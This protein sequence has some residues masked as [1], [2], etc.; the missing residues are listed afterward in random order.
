MSQGAGDSSLTATVTNAFTDDGDVQSTDGPLSGSGDTTVFHYDAMR[1]RTGI[2]GPDPDSGGSLHNRALRYTYDGDGQVTKVERGTAPS[3][4]DSD[5]TSH[6][7]TLEELDTTYNSLAQRVQDAFAAGGTTY[8]VTQYSYDSA[9]RPDCTA[10][11]LNPSIFGSLPSSA[12]TLGTE[13][14]NGPD[15]ISRNVYDQVNRVIQVQGAYGTA[16]QQTTA[17]QTWTGNSQLATLADANGNLTTYVHDGFDRLSKIEFP[18]ATTAG[19]SN[20]SDYEGYGYDANSNVTSDRRRDG[21][22]FALTYDN[23]NRLITAD[24]PTGT[25]DVDYSY[26]LFGRRT[27]AQTSTQTLTWAYDQL[28]RN[29][30]AGAPLGTVSYQYDLAGQR[31]RITWPDSLYAQYDYDLTGAV[32]AIRENGAT[33]GAGVL[34]TYAYDDYARRTSITRGNGVTTTY[35]YDGSTRLSSLAHDLASTGSDQTISYTYNAG[36]QALTRTGT[37]ASY[38]YTPPTG[39]AYTPPNGLNQ[40]VS[41]NAATLSYDTR[42]NLTSDGTVSYSYDAYNRLTAAGSA[43]LSYDPASRLYQTAGAATT[44]FLSDGGEVIA[45]Y[46]TSGTLLRRFVHGPGIDEPIVWY[47]GSGTSDRR[48]LV[49]NEQNTVIAVT[50]AS[51]AA[52]TINTYDEYG[53]PG[54]SNAGRFQF[55]GQM[56]LPEASQYDFKARM[57][58]AAL[59]RFMQTDP[60][61]Q[62]GGLNIYAYAGGDPVNSLDPWGLAEF[63][64]V[65]EIITFGSDGTLTILDFI[66]RC[67]NVNTQLDANTPPGD[68]EERE[69]RSIGPR[70]ATRQALCMAGLNEDAAALAVYGGT[71]EQQDA[72]VGGTLSI[73][74]TTIALGGPEDPLTWGVGI[75]LAEDSVTLYNQSSSVAATGQAYFNMH[76]MGGYGLNLAAQARHDFYTFPEA[77]PVP[78]PSRDGVMV[79]C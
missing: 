46:N 32:T 44:R 76:G 11:R 1:Q 14:S 22:S 34:A 69:Q 21:N 13:G 42:G 65:R 10:V 6:F 78:I 23:L 72:I 20:T 77:E 53:V 45:E 27:Q 38:V 12:C 24:A 60:I 51:G 73:V 2:V 56:W 75:H 40:L 63:C 3:Q 67:R 48:W 50:D 54:S 70:L 17:T 19:S 8:N 7:T 52:L 16:L 5:W 18:S 59:G 66:A 49:Q 47:E 30:S 35:S 33:S 43:T 61:L 25:A 39:Y 29:T 15:R 9:N 28:S 31:T 41:N 26:D 68:G 57:Y 37:N 62:N 55:T 4:S 71:Y 79:P 36:N 64:F 58:S 74:G